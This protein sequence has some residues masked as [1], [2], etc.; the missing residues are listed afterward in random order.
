MRPSKSRSTAKPRW[1]ARWTISVVV[2][3]GVELGEV[4]DGVDDG[5][6]HERQVGEGEALLGLER[7][8]GRVPDLVDVVEVDLD[9]GEDVGRRGQRSGPCARPCAGGCWRTARPRRPPAPAVAG[10]RGRGGGRRGPAAAAGGGGAAAAGRGAAPAAPRSRWARTSSRVMRPAAGARDLVGVEVVLGDQPAD[11]RRQH[12]GGP[13]RL[14]G[15]SPRGRRRAGRA[16]GRAGGAG[17]R[18]R[19]R[20]PPA[21]ARLRLGS[22]SRL[23]PAARRPAASRGRRPSASAGGGLGASAGRALAVRVA[24]AGAGG[25]VGD[26]GQLGARRRRCRPPAPGSR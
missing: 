7:V 23:R 17:G 22:A 26:D 8:L 15:P 6:G 24:A 10:D 4:A 25:L 20:A 12:A 16:A 18:R 14:D 9:R 3:R 21:R 1:T 11:D 19:R 5:P 13:C 2:D